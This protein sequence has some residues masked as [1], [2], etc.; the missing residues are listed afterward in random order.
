MKCITNIRNV[1]I[2]TAAP[3]ARFKPESESNWAHEL[4]GAGFQLKLICAVTF[5]RLKQPGNLIV[6]CQ[7]V[8]ITIE[9]PVV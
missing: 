6:G 4:S 5:W 1:R 8:R 2:K 7:I 3:I 9:H